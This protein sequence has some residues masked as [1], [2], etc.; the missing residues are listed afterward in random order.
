M[1]KIIAFTICAFATTAAF[2]SLPPLSPE[3]QAEAD[4]KKAKTAY[5]GKVGAYQLCQ[6]Q[7]KIADRFKVSGTPAP[8]AC[9][10]PPPFTPPVAAAAPAAPAAK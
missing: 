2:A 10:A 1:K 6:I 3:A 8:G 9:T 5:A 4:L 7:N